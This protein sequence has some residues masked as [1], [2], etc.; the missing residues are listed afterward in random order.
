M[1]DVAVSVVLALHNGRRYLA[2]AVESV[3]TQTLRPLELLVVDDGSTDGG[4]AV[5]DQ[6]ALPFE[7]TVLTQGN[8]GQSAARNR[9]VAAARGDLV[10]FL[11]QDD[12]WHR[13]HLEM[14]CA[15]LD[16]PAV[17]WAYSDFDEIDGE[18]RLVTMSFL[19]EHHIDHP[20]RTLSACISADLMVL[21]SASV[22]RRQA[23]DEV[24]GFD[25]EL[26]GYEDD[27]LYVRFFRSGWRL[28]FVD[29]PL[30]SFRVHA[31]SSSTDHTFAVSRLRYGEKLRA[32]VVDDRRLSRFWFRDIVAPRF[33]HASLDD[34]VRAVS[35]R[36]WIAAEQAWRAVEVFAEEQV[37]TIPWRWKLILLRN[38]RASRRLLELNQQLPQW[39]RLTRNP[40]YR[41]R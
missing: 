21:P 41:L 38:P 12:R 23:F 27:D 33:L 5:L 10:A 24:G 14:L 16:D 4:V 13:K 36:D 8:A 35:A 34:Y 18:G 11:D 15:R 17:G 1:S 6:L 19:A 2:E 37:S 26:R 28:A 7:V 3:A 31:N 9:G 22:V 30:T 40:L 39:A 29:E 25:E 32:S 20:K